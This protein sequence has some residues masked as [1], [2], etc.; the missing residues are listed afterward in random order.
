VEG[1]SILPLIF[2]L[3][4]KDDKNRKFSGIR[5]YITGKTGE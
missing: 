1:D 2:R 5:K 3:K 4:I